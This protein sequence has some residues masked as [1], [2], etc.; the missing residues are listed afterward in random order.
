MPTSPEAELGQPHRRAVGASVSQSRTRSAGGR[1]GAG[2]CLAR[3]TVQ[4]VLER[5]D[6]EAQFRRGCD[7]AAGH[8]RR[9]RIE[10]RMRERAVAGTAVLALVRGIVMVGVVVRGVVV[11][12]IVV[13]RVVVR[14]A[15][16]HEGRLAQDQVQSLRIGY[17][18][19]AHGQQCA[20]CQQWQQQREDQV[21]AA[22]GHAGAMVLGGGAA[23]PAGLVF[24]RKSTISPPVTSAT[25]PRG[26]PASRNSREMFGD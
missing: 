5:A 6:D 3:R 11:R 24:V 20:Q 23:R 14:R 2:A 18:H 10:R 8:M 26:Y 7:D 25:A 15:R 17:R 4:Q 21:Q 16:V 19:V 22:A 9:R 1:W 13:R 12:G